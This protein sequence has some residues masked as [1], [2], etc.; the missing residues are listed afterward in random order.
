MGCMSSLLSNEMGMTCV[1]GC[2]C[3]IQIDIWVLRYSKIDAH[4]HNRAS[5]MI[6]IAFS[7][8][9]E[10]CPKHLPTC[11]SLSKKHRTKIAKVPDWTLYILHFLVVITTFHSR[12]RPYHK[13]HT[14]TFIQTNLAISLDTDEI[15]ESKHWFKVVSIPLFQTR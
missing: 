2:M 6:P 9:D 12:Y 1:S 4:L 10:L 14:K 13:V 11:Q 8:H 7:F 15:N 3:S 5:S